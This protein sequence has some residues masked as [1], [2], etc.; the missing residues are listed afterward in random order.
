M[1]TL[2]TELQTLSVELLVTSI[3]QHSKLNIQNSALDPL[4]SLNFSTTLYGYSLHSP[5]H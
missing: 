4:D 2:N 1:L 3:I 5:G